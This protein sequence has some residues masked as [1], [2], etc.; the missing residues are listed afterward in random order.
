M[1]LVG[2]RYFNVFGPRQDPYGA[3]AAVIPLFIKHL[4][5]ESSPVVNG[6]GSYSRDFTYIANVVQANQRAATVANPEAVNTVYNVACG[7]RTT[8]NE[9]VEVL[10]ELLTPYNPKI[11]KV[12]IK[13]G[14][15]RLGDIPHSLASIEKA[16]KLL[17]YSP[18]HQIKDGLKEAIGWYWE[19]LK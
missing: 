9:L 10:K 17:G 15:E 2:L 18:T 12:E 6:D 11:A 7:A 14:P 3:Y 4:M 13:H 19:N 1:E 8:L 16:Q 5:A